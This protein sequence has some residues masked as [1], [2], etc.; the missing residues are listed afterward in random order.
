MRLDTLA[1]A[2]GMPLPAESDA[3]VTGFAIDH[4]KV[5]PGPVFG[6]FRDDFG[7]IAELEIA[8]LLI[9][10]HTELRAVE[11][12]KHGLAATLAPQIADWFVT[13]TSK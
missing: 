2:A 13:F 11:G 1:A 8:R 3:A 5:A 10:A 9:P 6:A 12:G 4:R 7:T